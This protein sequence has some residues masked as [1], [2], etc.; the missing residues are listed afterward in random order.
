[1]TKVEAIERVM[2]DYG[3]IATLNVIYSEI[4]KYYPNAKA[5]KEWKAGIRGV[6]YR[7]LGKRFKK[8]DTSVYALVNYDLDNLIPNATDDKKIATTEKE[9]I[10]QVRLYQSKYREQL[11]KHLKQ[12]PFTGIT[13]KRLLVASHIK[14]WC[15]SSSEE[16]LDIYNGFILSPLYDRLFDQGLI[17]FTSD[18]HIIYSSTLSAKTLAIIRIDND[19]CE[20]LP[21][22]HREKYLQ[23]HNEKIFIK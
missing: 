15:L 11:L 4:E 1:M 17:T 2:L 6:L 22:A 12:C 21:A 5:S 7:D 9:V 19:Y 16:K 20:N 13:D 10:A 8:I 3:G 14:P 18:K 23:F